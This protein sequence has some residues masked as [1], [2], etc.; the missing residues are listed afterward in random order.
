MQ[1]EQETSQEQ[2][3]IPLSKWEDYYDYP[4]VSTLRQLVFKNTANF[5]N[6]VLVYIGKRQYISPK[7][8]FSWAAKTKI[9]A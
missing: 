6:E 2:T 3:I 7:L 8:F 9:I 5:K 4:K 1:N